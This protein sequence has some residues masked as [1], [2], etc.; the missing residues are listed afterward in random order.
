MVEVL[1]FIVHRLE[2]DFRME[3]SATK[4]KLVAG[5]PAV[6]R[7]VATTTVSDDGNAGSS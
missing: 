6:A 5:R 4:A 7:A 3:V 2:V 1:D